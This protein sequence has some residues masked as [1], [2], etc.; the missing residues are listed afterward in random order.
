MRS[1]PGWPFGVVG[2]AATVAAW[3]SNVWLIRRQ[4]AWNDDVRARHCRYLP[5][6]PSAHLYGGAA[7][8]LGVLAAVCLIVW[9]C[10][11]ARSGPRAWVMLV[12][13]IGVAAAMLAVGIGFLFAVGAPTDPGQGTDGSGL[14]CG[15]G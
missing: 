13:L 4:D 12:V 14:P 5:P 6:L 3:L 8:V 7:M 1:L 11:D 15:S 10:L 9:V 2:V